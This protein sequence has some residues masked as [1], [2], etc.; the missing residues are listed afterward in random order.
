VI[1]TEVAS[2]ANKPMQVSSPRKTWVLACAGSLIVQ[3]EDD[4]HRSANRIV[5]R[6]CVVTECGVVDANLD[7]LAGAEAEV[8]KLVACEAHAHQA[9]REPLDALDAR[10]ASEARLEYVGE[11]LGKCGHD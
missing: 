4:V 1:D 2:D 5:G 10:A 9:W 6:R 7:L 8:A 3:E 11:K